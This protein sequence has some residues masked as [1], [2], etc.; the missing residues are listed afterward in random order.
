MFNLIFKEKLKIASNIRLT[1]RRKRMVNNT[2]PLLVNYNP[3]VWEGKFIS[4]FD[5]YDYNI[6]DTEDFDEFKYQI[7]KSK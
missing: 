6:E 5:N 4:P 7:N 2:S 1:Q 3:K